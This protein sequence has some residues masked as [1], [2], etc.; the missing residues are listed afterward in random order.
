MLKERNNMFVIKYRPK[1]LKDFVNQKEALAKFL[2]WYKKWKPGS[3]AALLYG[4]PGTG[5]TCL[6]EAFARD[7]NLE[8][9]QMNASDTRSK[10]Q[11]EEVFGYASSVASFFKKG[12]IFL[13]DEVDG[14]AGK[15]DAGGISAII[16][17]IK[18]SKHPVVLTANDPYDPNLRFLRQ[19]C[20]LIPF[21]GIPVWDIEKKLK[22]IC[23]REGI[24]YDKEV[25]RQLAK[26]SE[27]DLR[28][29]IND[30]ETVA[31][32][33]N[34]INLKDLDVL[35]FREREKDM[36][37]ALKILFKT[38]SF[39]AARLSVAD[40]DLEPEN[41]MLWIEENI[42]NEYEK[43]DEIAKAYEAL[44]KADLF[45]A[46]IINRNYW[47]L[48]RY[49]NDLMTA[50]VSLAKSE[51]YR[52]FVKYQ[53]PSKIRYLSSIKEEREEEKEKL[54]KLSK[55]LNCSTKKVKKEFLPFFKIFEKDESFQKFM[56]SLNE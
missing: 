28:A 46:R 16:K 29:A 19:Y 13:I 2:E 30:L 41:I 15:E 35:G 8:L 4:K 10:K 33:K 21:S 17:I 38:S 37:E 32:G 1:S 6:V 45:R 40:V 12:R 3:K 27:G 34:K 51:M 54:Q 53:F 20:E 42:A 26:R 39:N 55:I 52:K 49:M 7:E 25:L 50:G 56:D 22:E 11:I 31:S 43:P 47:K 9:I 36:F 14:I 5:K 44:A 24:E 23:E 18:E 48:M